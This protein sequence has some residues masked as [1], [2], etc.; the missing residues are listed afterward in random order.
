MAAGKGEDKLRRNTV[1]QLEINANLKPYHMDVKALMEK[2][3]VQD[4]SEGP[5]NKGQKRRRDQL[6]R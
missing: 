3:T 1:L 5:P 2:L 4:G 6:G